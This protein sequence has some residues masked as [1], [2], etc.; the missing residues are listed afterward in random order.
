[1]TAFV[2]KITSGENDVTL[3]AEIFKDGE[4]IDIKSTTVHFSEIEVSK[5]ISIPYTLPSDV[6]GISI[7]AYLWNTYT[8]QAPI[9]RYSKFGSDNADIDELF[10]YGNRVLEFS[11]LVSNYN[12]ILPASAGNNILIDSLCGDMATAVE[13]VHIGNQLQLTATSSGGETKT[14][15]I[16]YTLANPEIISAEL[17][18][19]DTSGTQQT[20][21]GTYQ[22]PDVHELKLPI[23]QRDVDG[24]IIKFGTTANFNNWK[25][26]RRRKNYLL[27]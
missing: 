19:Y 15:T 24:K 12:L 21:E 13:K 1:M 8:L 6:T 16:D 4:V 23:Y 14:Y 25:C 20:G 2:K 26:N 7:E 17:I 22:F 5:T 27:P 3:I 9:A 11:P 18:Y 10:I